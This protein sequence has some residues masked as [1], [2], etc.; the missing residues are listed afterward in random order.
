MTFLIREGTEVLAYMHYNSIVEIEVSDRRTHCFALASLS[1]NDPAVAIGASG[2]VLFIGSY[3][4]LYGVELPSAEL[5]F[6]RVLPEGPEVSDVRPLKVGAEDAVV[7]VSETAIRLI[8][9][10]GSVRWTVEFEDPVKIIQLTEK[11]ATCRA[12]VPDGA[13]KFWAARIDL[14]SGESSFISAD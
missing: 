13:G 4:T 11:E 12:L 3:Q 10:D 5:L 9:E 14:A 7:V 6:Q 2:K 1:P 8:L